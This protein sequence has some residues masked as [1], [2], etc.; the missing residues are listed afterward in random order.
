[1]RKLIGLGAFAATT[2]GMLAPTLMNT[3]DLTNAAAMAIV[4]CFATVSIAEHY[5]E[6][7]D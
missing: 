7:K 2:A 5:F 6:L 3:T 1:M 4:G